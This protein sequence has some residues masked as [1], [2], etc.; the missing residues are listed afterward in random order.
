[1]KRSPLPQSV[2]GL[3]RVAV[4][5]GGDSPEREISL[6]SGEAAFASLQRLGV[7]AVA[8][9]AGRDLPGHLRDAGADFAL[10][11]LHGRGGEDGAVQGLLEVL[12]I[13]GSGSGV[14]A[15]ALAMDKIM[16]KLVWRQLGLPTADFV[17]L[18]AQTDWQQV[19]SELGSVVVKPVAGGSSLGV[20]IAHDA[21]A[22]AEQFSLAAAFDSPV[23]AE[24]YIRGREFSVGILQD[25][26]MPA[27]EL[28]TQRKFFDYHAKYEDQA[29][30]YICPADLSAS[31]HQR[32]QA[33][34]HDAYRALGC[35]GLARVDLMHDQEGNFHLLEV[36]TV[37]GMTGH[38][39][40]PMAASRLGMSYDDLMRRIL[41]CEAEAQNP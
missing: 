38:S 6:R 37:P 5:M 40:I 35:C 33:L 32:L 1:M 22:L 21:A 17:S 24:R 31:Q 34:A 36:N 11:M 23:M 3:G 19:I 25:E 8:I 29:T 15:S 16:S 12:G 4:L 2:V 26:P 9:D 41:V 7:P 18:E 27:V 10:V 39:I 28:V 13:P 30:E 14:L 20:G